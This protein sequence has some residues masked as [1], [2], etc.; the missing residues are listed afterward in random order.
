[1]IREDRPTPPEM[2]NLYGNNCPIPIHKKIRALEITIGVIFGII[3]FVYLCF[4]FTKIM[5][6]VITIIAIVAFFY[7]IYSIVLLLML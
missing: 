3:L 4:A 6:I 5:G 1:M 2:D 7:L